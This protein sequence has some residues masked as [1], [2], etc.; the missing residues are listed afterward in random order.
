[1]QTDEWMAY[2]CSLCF[3]D[4]NGYKVCLILIYKSAKTIGLKSIRLRL[5]TEFELSR[6][7][8]YT[9]LEDSQRHRQMGPR[10]RRRRVARMQKG[11]FTAPY[12]I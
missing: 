8:V 4:Q 2:Y 12:R 3:S 10:P 1:M 7:N 9:V 6:K 5:E 11:G